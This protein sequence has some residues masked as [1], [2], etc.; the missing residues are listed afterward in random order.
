MAREPKTAVPG[1]TDGL[2][3]TL[4]RANQAVHRLVLEAIDGLPVTITQLGLVVHLDELGHMSAS[5]LARLFRLTPQSVSTALGHL[6]RI[7]WVRRRP[8]PV[9]GRVIWYEATDEG[10][11]GAEA[12][13]ERLAALDVRLRETLGGAEHD[14]L[15]RDL[16]AVGVAIDG[17]PQPAG[18]LWPDPVG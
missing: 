17:E 11:A 15:I 13:R 7:G 4:Y 9:H 16:R 1:W 5:D 8:H 14:E 6:E 18:P 12:G 10:L 2:P 3:Y